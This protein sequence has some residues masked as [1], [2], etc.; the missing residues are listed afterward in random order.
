MFTARVPGL[1]LVE[2]TAEQVDDYAR[3]LQRTHRPARTTVAW[4]RAGS[5]RWPTL[6]EA[7]C[8]RCAEPWPCPAA[9]WADGYQHSHARDITAVLR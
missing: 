1:G 5:I 7:A 3:E 2:W 6:T 8:N 4:R 9:W